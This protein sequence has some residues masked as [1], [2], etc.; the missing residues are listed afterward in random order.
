[1]PPVTAKAPDL[2]VVIVSLHR[3]PR[4]AARPRWPRSTATRY[5]SGPM[6]VVHVVDNASTDGT[7]EMVRDEFP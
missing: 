6:T 5:A 2:E 3:R 7:A 4:P 1:M